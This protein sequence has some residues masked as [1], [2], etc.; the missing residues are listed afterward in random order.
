[1]PKIGLLHHWYIFGPVSWGMGQYLK[2]Q[3][4]RIEEDYYVTSCDGHHNHKMPKNSLIRE[5]NKDVAKWWWTK[6]EL[7]V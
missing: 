2:A 5:V 3:I 1:M 4:V 6:E 7:D